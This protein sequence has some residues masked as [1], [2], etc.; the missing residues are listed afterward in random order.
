V[1]ELAAQHYPDLT[2]Y[3][4]A[5]DPEKYFATWMADQKSA[6]L[7]SGSFGRSAFSQ[8]FKKSFVATI[9]REHQVPVFVAH[10]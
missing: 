7:V 5:L 8:A 6:L 9:I 3:K 1:V 4:L 2:F 10:K